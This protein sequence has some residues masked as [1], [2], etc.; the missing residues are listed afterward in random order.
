MNETCDEL[1]DHNY[2][3]EKFK[4]A[5]KLWYIVDPYETTFENYQDVPDYHKQIWLSF[6]VLIILEQVI[7]FS[8]KKSTFRFND[9]FT[10]LSHWILQES[11]RLCLRGAEYYTYIKIYENYRIINL[12]WNSICTW[13]I[14][15]LGVDFCYYWVHRANHEVHFLWSQHQVHHSSEE[16]NLVVGLRQSVLQQWCSFMFYLPLAVFIPPSHFVAHHQF[17]LIYQL[18]IH[19]TLIDDL[20]LLE[21][22]LNTPK[23]HRIH[24]GCNLYCLDK[25]YGGVLIIWDRL[26]GTFQEKLPNQ[27]I[28]YGLVVSA[29]KFNPIYLQ[30]FYTRA[31]IN[32]SI[33]MKTMSDK[34]GVLWKGPSWLPG[35]PRLG[36]DEFKVNVTSRSIYDPQ[37]PIWQKIYIIIHFVIVF[38]FHYQLYQTKQNCKLFNSSL[39]INNV[40]TL[41]TI[42][43]LFDKFKYASVVELFRCLM[44]FIFIKYYLNNDSTSYELIC[45]VYL[46]CCCL[47]IMEIIYNATSIRRL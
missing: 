43:L 22:V 47:W 38:Y 26:F 33:K 9:H 15:A 23:H 25:N 32:Q 34:I 7:L 20:G 28:I 39:V 13:Y 16:F 2:M 4:H 6:F 12:P 36:L 40:I 31:M 29:R 41:T 19:T 1:V 42:G 35:L 8:K 24:H 37:L 44:Q 3:L 11:S 17:N 5:G 45:S 10:S 18:W 14:T 46:I 27:D 21:F 30:T